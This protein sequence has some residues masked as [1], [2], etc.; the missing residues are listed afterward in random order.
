[1]AQE[2]ID[3]WVCPAA[4]GPAPAGLH[5][6]GDPNLNLPWTHTGMPALTV[7]AGRADNG[8][9]LGLQLVARYDEDEALLAWSL[10]AETCLRAWSEAGTGTAT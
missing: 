9:P 6:T 2:G 4:P 10:A 8:L 7:P 1:M 3:G 5:A